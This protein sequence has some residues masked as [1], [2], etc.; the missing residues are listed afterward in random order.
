MIYLQLYFQLLSE[1]SLLILFDFVLYFL[2]CLIFLVLSLYIGRFLR[3]QNKYVSFS[4]VLVGFILTMI[5]IKGYLLLFLGFLSAVLFNSAVW[6]IH[7]GE[8]LHKIRKVKFILIPTIFAILLILSEQL[9]NGHSSYYLLPILFTD[10]YL[11]TSNY[12]V[13][14]I[15]NGGV[16]T[17]EVF[18]PS[19]IY[20]GSNSDVFFTPFIGIPLLTRSFSVDVLRFFSYIFIVVI[21][22]YFLHSQLPLKHKYFSV[23]VG[24]Y[25]AFILEFL[26]FIFI[27]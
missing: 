16:Q 22:G 2:L 15:V 27:R 14:S 4:V 26:L 23:S 20:G 1:S 8:N 19:N 17:F 25:S 6:G 5:T 13:T 11:P 7:Q 21:F 10:N 12:S 9:F 3:T 24:I 18:I